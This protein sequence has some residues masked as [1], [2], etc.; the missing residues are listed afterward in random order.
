VGATVPLLL[1]HVD[2]EPTQRNF[3]RLRTALAQMAALVGGR[4]T[5]LLSLVTGDN[6]ITPP[7]GLRPRGR[8][9]LYQDAPANLSDGGLQSD[10]RWKL[11]ST[12][13]CRVRLL[14]F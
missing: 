3:E 4:E 8:L 2:D 7:N 10:G 13:P 1:A 6:L 9:V 12:A 11:T 5:G 14:F